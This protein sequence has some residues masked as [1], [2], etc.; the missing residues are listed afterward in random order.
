[1][2]SWGWRWGNWDVGER[3]EGWWGLLVK[4]KG[5]GLTSIGNFLNL[6]V[7]FDFLNWK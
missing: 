1:M 2:Q 4:V 5:F 3:G 6:G 7:L